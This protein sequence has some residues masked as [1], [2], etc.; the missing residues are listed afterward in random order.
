MAGLTEEILRDEAGLTNQDA[1]D[2]LLELDAALDAA[3]AVLADKLLHDRCYHSLSDAV[4]SMRTAY[5]EVDT[6]Y[7]RHLAEVS[8]GGGQGAALNARYESNVG[9]GLRPGSDHKILY[10]EGLFTHSTNL[11]NSRL[12][13]T[14]ALLHAFEPLPTNAPNQTRNSYTHNQAKA[15]ITLVRNMH[16]IAIGFGTPLVAAVQEDINAT[17][18]GLNRVSDVRAAVTAAAAKVPLPAGTTF[19]SLGASQNRSPV[20]TP[21]DYAAMP[22]LPY[23]TM[24]S[25]RAHPLSKFRHF[26][27]ENVE[28]SMFSSAAS[29]GGGQLGH[30]GFYVINR[31]NQVEEL[32][33]DRGSGFEAQ[34]LNGVIRNAIPNQALM[35]QHVQL[36]DL[37]DNAAQL[38]AHDDVSA[39]GS[40][41]Q[42][43]ASKEKALKSYEQAYSDEEHA[44]GYQE[45]NAADHAWVGVSQ[46]FLLTTGTFKQLFETYKTMME[47][48]NLVSAI[49][50]AHTESFAAFK[51]AGVDFIAAQTRLLDAW[52]CIANAVKP[53]TDAKHELMKQLRE[54]MDAG[55]SVGEV[56]SFGKADGIDNSAFN[57]LINDINM[58]SIVG[59]VAAAVQRNIFKEQCFLLSYMKKLAEVKKTRDSGP[60]P[61][62]PWTIGTE[63]KK[64]LPYVGNNCNSTLLLDGDPYGL[65]NKMVQS[66]GSSTFFNTDSEVISHLQPMIRLYKVT[67]DDDG[68]AYEDEF[69]F[70]SSAVNLAAK[71]HAD[72]KRRGAGVGVQSFN[73]AYEGSNPFAV[74][75]SISATLKVFASSMDELLEPRKSS[76]NRDIAFADLALK[77]RNPPPSRTPGQQSQTPGL[78][79]AACSTSTS[80]TTPSHLS[81]TQN[82]NLDKLTFRL[83]AVV[84]WARPNG[85]GPWGDSTV[86]QSEKSQLYNGIWD[87]SITLNLTPTVHSFEFD[88]LGRTVMNIN[89]LAYVDDF[90]DQPAFNVFASETSTTVN[91]TAKQLVRNMLLEHYTENC[92]SEDLAT[93]KENM[94][95]EVNLEKQEI[96]QA[97]VTSLSTKEKIYTLRLN[98]ANISVFLSKG[99]FE[100]WDPTDPPFDFNLSALSADSDTAASDMQA[101]IDSFQGFTAD[102]HSDQNTNLFRSGLQ[103]TDPKKETLPFFYVSDLIDCIL[104]NIETELH[105]MPTM[106]TAAMIQAQGASAAG[107]DDNCR[108]ESEK[109]KL[110]RL[111][112]AYSK[113]RIVLGPLEVVDQSQASP[114]NILHCTFGDVP[115]ALKYFLEWMT[116]QMVGQQQTI[117]SLTRF[118]NDLFNKLIQDFLNDGSCFGW[119]IKP[120]GKVRMNQTVVTSYPRPIISTAS[121]ISHYKFDEITQFCASAGRVRANIENIPRPV[122][123]ISG[124]PGIPNAAG[125][126]S[127]EM[128]YFVF[129]A[130][131][132]APIDQMNGNKEEDEAK[133][134]YHYMIGRNKGLI[135]TIKLNKTDSQGLAEVRFE[136]EGYEG[137]QQLRVLYDADIDMYSNVKTFPG[138]YI[139]V[140]PRGFAPTTNLDCES[141]LNLTQYGIGGYMMIIKSEHSFGPGKAETKLHAKWV[142]GISNCAGTQ[143]S[144][145]GQQGVANPTGNSS[146]GQ[147]TGALTAARTTS[148]GSTP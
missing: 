108:I 57:G 65:I 4:I 104:E 29:A 122:F 136:Q 130:G 69:I 53:Y 133:G 77:T 15:L 26:R 63:P 115:I 91:P 124:D 25:N 119:D 46:T 131:R 21:R 107:L 120:G 99:P 71:L 61:T 45:I 143:D 100:D 40:Q 144:N 98:I 9:Y 70:E 1:I 20:R 76:N 117:Y 101:A 137:L 89:Y 126:V 18:E 112:Q 7:R 59:R 125:K 32:E 84:G 55:I 17:T 52:V 109:Q 116:E 141:P 23:T 140:D 92:D 56:I 10:G 43:E 60:I 105:N 114:S 54:D 132:V 87:S 88:D 35:I 103:A 145:I 96:L 50:T 146:P 80:A 102:P 134:I 93:V 123:R 42:S 11:D 83:K 110:R 135:K 8:A 47:S 41:P 72:K 34:L 38:G 139:F 64:Y 30:D 44:A 97:L 13:S 129:S 113:L 5:M 94:A 111:K 31:S 68:K 90:Y 12:A 66:E 27:K 14:P 24:D 128:N 48:S 79:P 51:V 121:G 82:A 19:K 2:G 85:N 118:I 39:E 16:K 147:C 33:A 62:T 73:F 86:P 6:A 127:E 148:A 58:E 74:K 81:A 78:H 95:D 28:H 142:N 37:P 75:K 36:P 22:N 106:I 49:K 67:Y 138:T 3:A